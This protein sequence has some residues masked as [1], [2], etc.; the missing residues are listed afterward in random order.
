MHKVILYYKYINIKDPQ[1]A[2]KQQKALCASLDLKG[3]ILIASEGINGTLEGTEENILKY[4]EE[5]NSNP[6]FNTPDEKRTE[7]ISLDYGQYGNEKKLTAIFAANVKIKVS[8]SPGKAFRKLI[9]KE[10]SEIVTSHLPKEIEP[11]SITGKYLTAEELHDWYENKREFYIVDMRNDYETN[12]GYFENSIASQIGNFRY[13]PEVLEKIEHLKDKT[14][15]TVCTGGVRCE[16]A[17]GFLMYNGFKDVYQL[18]DGIVTYME[19]FP[20]EHFKGKLYVFDK[21]FLVGFNTSDPKHEVVGKCYKCKTTCENFVNCSYDECHYHFI[22]CDNCKQNGK[23]F[24]SMKC[25]RIIFSKNLWANLL[26]KIW[27]KI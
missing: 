20:N 26:E 14:I 9:V 17:S 25:K 15:V 13:L 4:C 10:R 6:L 8:D 3:R 19:K 12:V 18:K 16:K 1:A 7:K 22:C 24:C 27:I 21:R 23:A 11:N 2:V 5:F